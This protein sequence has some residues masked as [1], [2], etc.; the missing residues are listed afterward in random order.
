MSSY[1]RLFAMFL[2]AIL[3]MIFTV[4]TEGAE[5]VQLMAT[6]DQDGVQRIEVLAGEYFFKP[7]HIVVKAAVPVEI[8]IKKEPEVIR[9]IP[10][11]P[12]SYPFY[13]DKK[14]LFFKSH[15]EQGIEG[16]LDRSQPAS[17]GLLFTNWRGTA[18]FQS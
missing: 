5:G 16:I 12:G 10:S 1:K 14:L 3:Q 4:P 7:N 15:R 18:I 2:L 8:T 6:V 17:H 13:C 11:K 9:F